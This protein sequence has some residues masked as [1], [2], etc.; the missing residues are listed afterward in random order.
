M[1]VRQTFSVLSPKSR[2]KA[3][4]MVRIRTLI[5][6]FKRRGS[7]A[8]H[9][10]QPWFK[11]YSL[12]SS[13]RLHLPS[14]KPSYTWVLQYNQGSSHYLIHISFSICISVCSCICLSF[15][16]VFPEPVLLLRCAC[17][18]SIHPHCKA[19]CGL[20]GPFQN[21][22]PSHRPRPGSPQRHGFEDRSWDIILGFWE[23]RV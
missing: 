17:A 7:F 16:S 13:C 22:Q 10:K 9:Q 6:R 21:V 8:S 12:L 23:F 3:A 11:P 4:L 20:S 15:S 2:V 18:F 19:E 1:W 5:G 14:E